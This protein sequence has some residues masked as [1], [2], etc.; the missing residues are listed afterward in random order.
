MFISHEIAKG[1]LVALNFGLVNVGASQTDVQLTAAAV[2]GNADGYGAPWAGD[3]VGIGWALSA[4]STAGV[5]TVGAT[6]G[7][8]ENANTTLTFPADSATTEGYKR[9][10]RGKASFAAGARLGAEIT[11]DG[12]WLPTTTDLTVT[13]YVLYSLD[14]I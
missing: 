8:T 5:G 10:P 13:V 1:Q 14:G 9:I 4:A 12:S 6:V 3:V 7:G 2:S 11:T